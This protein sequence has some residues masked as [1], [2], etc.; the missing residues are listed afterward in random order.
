[1]LRKGH[2]ALQAGFLQWPSRHGAHRLGVLRQP[3]QLRGFGAWWASP[4]VLCESTPGAQVT[5]VAHTST[6]AA[7]QLTYGAGS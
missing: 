7:R 5:R 1:M 4:G 2:E 3:E 6:A